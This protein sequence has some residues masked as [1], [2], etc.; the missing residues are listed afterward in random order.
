MISLAHV[1]ETDRD[2]QLT[3]LPGD[4]LYYLLRS[5]LEASAECH[6]DEQK[7]LTA[8][9]TWNTLTPIRCSLHHYSSTVY[10]SH[11]LASLR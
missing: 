6:H 5:W 4:S 2:L 8:R 9:G 1:A 3:F 11:L 10:A 7:A